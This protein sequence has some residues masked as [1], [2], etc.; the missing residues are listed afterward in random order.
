[1]MSDTEAS[2]GR[3]R[4]RKMLEYGAVPT[5]VVLALHEQIAATDFNIDDIRRTGIIRNGLQRNLRQ[6]TSLGQVLKLALHD[7]L[8]TDQP[9]KRAQA[10]RSGRT[11]ASSAPPTAEPARQA[12]PESHQPRQ[13]GSP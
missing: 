2:G 6:L 12:Q 5:Y 4:A 11:G 1:M 7:L 9:M 3:A 13:P 8:T 10:A